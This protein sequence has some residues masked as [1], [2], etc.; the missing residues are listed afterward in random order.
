M[1]KKSAVLITTICLA[2]SVVSCGPAQKVRRTFALSELSM[3][4]RRAE[5]AGD[6]ERALE[7]WQEYV[8]RRP[9][10]HFAEFELGR[11]ESQMGMYT[12]SIEHLTTAHDLRPGNIEYIEALGDTYILAGRVEDMMMLMRETVSEGEAGSGYLRLARY[13]QQVDR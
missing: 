1:L 3:E 12:Q 8:D 10:A 9:H 6:L 7:L 2:V 13:A 11:I 5:S 4:A